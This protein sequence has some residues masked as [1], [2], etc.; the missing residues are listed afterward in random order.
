M[1]KKTFFDGHIEVSDTLHRNM[2][3]ASSKMTFE[4]KADIVD[5]TIKE[6]FFR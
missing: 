1:D 2:D 4:V 3:L 5:V 6:M